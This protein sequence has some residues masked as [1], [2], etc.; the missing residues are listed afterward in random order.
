[1]G[2]AKVFKAPPGNSARSRYSIRAL[3]IAA[4]LRLTACDRRPV[5][6]E[7][8]KVIL[9][10]FQAVSGKDYPSATSDYGAR[11]FEKDRREDSTAVVEHTQAA[12]GSYQKHLILG[13]QKFKAPPD[14]GSGAMSVLQ[15][16][17]ACEKYSAW[18]KI[19]LLRGTAG[20]DY[21]IVDHTIQFEG[22]FK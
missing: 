16:Q 13:G 22:F 6:P 20:Q 8:D 19:T 17:T 9:H 11:F 12:L 2:G 7:A 14:H 3:L 1:M 18:E 4:G 15:R 5:T 21:K 10:R